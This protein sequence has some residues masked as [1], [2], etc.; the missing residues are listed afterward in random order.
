M[1]FTKKSNHF[2]HLVPSLL[3]STM[4]FFS[5]VPLA[6]KEKDEAHD[7]SRDPTNQEA[8]PK[9]QKEQLTS[10]CNKVLEKRDTTPLISR[11]ELRERFLKTHN[12]VRA[13]YGLADLTW[14]NYL[15]DYA[16]R[17]AN[18]LRDK[19]QCQMYH[20]NE[21]GILEGERYGE[22]LAWNWISADVAPNEF[23]KSPEFA[24]LGWSKEC[25][26]YDYAD[27]SCTQGK[28]CGHFTQVVWKESQKVGCGVAI[29]DGKNNSEG[30]G[31]AEVWVCNYDPPGNVRITNRKGKVIS[32]KPF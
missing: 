16:Q 13:I 7:D 5:C 24:N 4:T 20:R 8:R 10:M 17:W 31:R 28:K 22:N 14:D 30:R 32:I 1:A 19:Y 26:D 12:E 27:G 21:L 3:V 18:Y 23:K 2:A 6:D 15:A 9:F 29:C 25:I 11:S